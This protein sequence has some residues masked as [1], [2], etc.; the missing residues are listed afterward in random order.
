MPF[1]R[2]DAGKVARFG[3][4]DRERRVTALCMGEDG[5]AVALTAKDLRNAATL[6]QHV[7]NGAELIELVDLGR[8]ASERASEPPVDLMFE[9]DD[10]VY[11]T[12]PDGMRIHGTVTGL[13]ALTRI[14]VGAGHVLVQHLLEITFYQKSPDMRDQPPLASSDLGAMLNVSSGAACAMLVAGS[15]HTAFALPLH[16]ALTTLHLTLLEPESIRNS[17]MVQETSQLL[18]QSELG[19]ETMRY[20]DLLDEPIDLGNPPPL[21]WAA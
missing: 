12:A 11:R 4:S 10:N 5:R 18:Q 7:L 16:N 3:L 6:P 8:A 21:R 2:V 19:V 15:G 17:A 13:R 1:E 20:Q 9:W 14:R